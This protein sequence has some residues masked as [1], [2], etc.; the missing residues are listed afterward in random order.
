MRSLALILLAACGAASH[1]AGGVVVDRFSKAAAHLLIGKGEP[2]T[3][4]DLDVAPFVTQGLAPDGHPVRY[5]NFDVQTRVPATLYRVVRPGST[6]S[7]ADL[8]DVLPGQPGYNDFWQVATVEVA[9]GVP[10]TVDAV[11]ALP[12]RRAAQAIDCPIVPAGTKHALGGDEH[13]VWYRGTKLTCLLFGEPLLL[14]GDQVPTSPI[15][16]TFKGAG[17]ANDGTAQ[18]HNVVFSV[19]GDTEYSPLWAVHVYDVSA[20]DQV[21]DAASAEAAKLVEPHGP[22]VN[23]PI[24]KN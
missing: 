16:V 3:P 14:E 21:H 24:V 10:T 15:Y 2:N 23:C 8:V 7:I 1:P 13:A 19:P 17:F 11:R 18:T 4:V 5:Y 12:A 6:E 9:D 22:L 20:F